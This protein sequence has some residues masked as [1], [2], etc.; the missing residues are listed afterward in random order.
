MQSTGQNTGIIYNHYTGKIGEEFKITADL[1]F[2]DDSTISGSYYYDINGVPLSLHGTIYPDKNLLLSETNSYFEKSAEIEAKLLPDGAIKGKINNLVS[3]KKYK[4]ELKTG[5]H[6]G[7]L[8]LK[9]F[10][11][12]EEGKLFNSENSPVF[13]IEYDLLIPSDS[14]KNEI[15]DSITKY[16]YEG[17]FSKIPEGEPM[18]KLRITADTAIDAYRLNNSDTTGYSDHLFMLSWEYQSK[19][20]VKH[21][22]HNVLSL[23][24]NTYYYMGGAHGGYGSV[25]KNIEL[26]SGKIIFLKDIIIAGSNGILRNALNKNLQELFDLKPGDR[27]S[28]IGFWDDSVDVPDNFYL[29]SGGIGFYFNPYDVACYA[30]GSIDVF[31]PYSEIS[32]I[33]NEKF[34]KKI[35]GI[36][37]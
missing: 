34:L 26:S 35:S 1:I 17:F 2:E 36:A 6:D 33:L 5:R 29:T 15:T 24:F 3:K 32:A 16:I 22:A 27:L 25:Y 9:G 18:Q 30:N 19:M 14:N 11:L 8:P 31:I 37:E 28:E 20:K 13:K 7:T 23:E 21:N 4:L 10:A 12:R